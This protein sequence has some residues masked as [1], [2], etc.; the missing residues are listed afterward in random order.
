MDHESVNM[1]NCTMSCGVVELSR[2]GDDV[3]KVL[4]QLAS[5]LYH[6]SRGSPCAF[7][8]WSDVTFDGISDS[9]SEKLRNAVE[10]ERFGLIDISSRAE[11]PR[12]SN[13][14]QI[15]IWNIKHKRFKAWYSK[16]RVKRIKKVG[17]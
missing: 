9:N 13:I 8:V 5:R 15:Y 12:T 6:P 7:F 16:E 4:Y 1:S 14:I 11:N 3:D 17:T 10:Y 2:I